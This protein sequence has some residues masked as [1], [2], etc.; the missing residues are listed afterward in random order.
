[1]T[2]FELEQELKKHKY[3]KLEDFLRQVRLSED[4]FIDIVCRDEIQKI[5]SKYKKSILTAQEASEASTI[6]YA[7]IMRRKKENKIKFSQEREGAPILFS[8]RYL[9]V[10]LYI[11][12]HPLS[13]FKITFT[14]LLQEL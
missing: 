14:N 9:A 13:P 12:A 1:M 6:S 8:S 5:E 3:I 7:T 10:V 4:E 2:K 11:K